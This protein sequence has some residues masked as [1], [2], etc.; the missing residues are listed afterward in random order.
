M[1]FGWFTRFTRFVTH[2]FGHFF[3]GTRFQFIIVRRPNTNFGRL[4][5]FVT[6]GPNDSARLAGRGRNLFLH[7]MRR[8]HHAVATVMGFAFVTSGFTV[9]T[10]RVM[11]GIIR[12][13]VIV[14]R[15]FIFGR[16]SLL[17]RASSATQGR[18]LSCTIGSNLSTRTV[19]R[20]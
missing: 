5:T 10:H 19:D 11:N 18:R 3:A 12:N 9:F 1:R 16:N 13:R 2:L 20:V 17:H 7:I 4:P 8:S 14:K 15:G 6:V